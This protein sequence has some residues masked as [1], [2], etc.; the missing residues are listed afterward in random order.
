MMNLNQNLVLFSCPHNSAEINKIL[1]F[2]M[3]EYR[4]RVEI[5]HSFEILNV[6]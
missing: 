6:F 5:K 2:F 1:S 4:G 3:I